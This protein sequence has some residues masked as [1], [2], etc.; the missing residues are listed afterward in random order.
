MSDVALVLGTITVDSADAPA[1]ADWWALVL[2]GSVEGFPEIGIQVVR[3]DRLR[4]LNLAVQH[5]ENPTPG[6][7]R[8]HLDFGAA[9]RAEAVDRLIGLGARRI[10]DN[11]FQGLGWTV[12]ADPDGNHFCVSDPQP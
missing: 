2:N 6:K 8:I 12:L 7:N 11:D 3:T 10:S 9:N 5:S 1:L 4:G